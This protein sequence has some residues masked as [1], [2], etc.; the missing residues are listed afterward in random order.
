MSCLY[1]Y[2]DVTILGKNPTSV[3]INVRPLYSHYSTATCFS[4]QLAILIGYF[5][6]GVLCYV[7][8]VSL[9]T[10]T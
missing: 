9:T 3:L 4:P 10:A 1:P 6:S 8:A 7:A 5:V 2:A